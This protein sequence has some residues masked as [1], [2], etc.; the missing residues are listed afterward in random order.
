MSVV[1][2]V[3]LAAQ[4]AEIVDEVREGFEEVFAD[5]S[6]IQG[7]A[8]AAFEGEFAR[9]LG[10]AHCVG[11]ANGT[12][13]LEI[14]LR[15]AG[16]GHGDEVVLPANTFVAT[17]EAV[18]RAGASPVLV[19][20]TPDTLLI[21]PEQVAAAIGP[22][23]RA[24]MPVH[25]YGQA[26][27]ME[28][29]IPIAAQ[30]GII[31]IEDA[32][33][34]QGARRNGQATGT[35]GLLAGTSFYP[36]KNLGAYGDAGAVVTNSEAVARTARLISN[37]GSERRYVHEVL[38]FNSR[39]DTLQ[40]VV[41]KAKLARLE[42]WNCARRRAANL[43]ENLLGDVAGIELPV[44]A[45]G[46]QHVWHLYVVQV[47]DRDALLSNLNSKG[48]GAAIHYPVPIHCHPAFANLGK[49]PGSFPVAERAAGR[50]LSL[51][52]H[53]HLTSSQ[54]EYVA[55]TLVSSLS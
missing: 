3:D 55:E 39:L 46:N 24:I 19:D 9:Y 47:D 6:F 22:K 44:T 12:D 5:T 37:H 4:H 41:L 42:G 33:Q 32:A 17:A 34:S 16:V 26:A 8:V 31:V 30:A 14:A 13:A 50:I 15:A 10:A 49:G 7:R 40:A 38:G 27:E 28:T 23:T 29:L 51:P 21:D 52:L 2:L 1:P 25:L 54:Q 45:E 53:P 18:L 43:Y 20:V 48:I 11:V 36:G 35:F